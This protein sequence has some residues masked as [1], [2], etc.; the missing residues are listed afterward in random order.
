VQA[1]KNKKHEKAVVLLSG[2]IDSATALYIAK[3]KGFR[4]TALIFD[5]G[6]R[7]KKE[8]ES[9]RR[10]AAKAKCGYKVIKVDFPRKGSALLS[11][12]E[13]VPVRRSLSEIKKTIPS[14]YVPARNLIFLSI[15]ASFAESMKAKA[16]FIGAHSQDYPGYPDCRGEFFD[17][18]RKVIA[19]GTKYGKYLKIYAPLVNKK[20]S[21]IIK[22]AIRL[23][24][25]LELTWSCYKGGRAP[26]GVCDSCFFKKK[27]YKELN[28]KD[29]SYA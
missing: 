27:A 8:I 7:H 29:P 25:P 28:M 12:K 15:A 4:P 17:L 23:K 14:T 22:T 9:A 26:C 11:G 5:Y 20:K 13:R 1:S 10:I 16:V 2:G 6:Q 24:V 19:A 18:F 3:K 21:E